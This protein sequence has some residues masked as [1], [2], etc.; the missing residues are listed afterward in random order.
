[1]DS[2]SSPVLYIP[3]H[4]QAVDSTRQPPAPE[5]PEADDRKKNTQQAA[6]LAE[7]IPAYPDEQDLRQAS[8]RQQL[9]N[10]TDKNSQAFLAFSSD[11]AGGQEKG[12]FVD[13]VV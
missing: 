6:S 12:R 11:E 9:F 10:N 3:A 8:G 5:R 7:Y 4:H 2:L 1:M 13:V